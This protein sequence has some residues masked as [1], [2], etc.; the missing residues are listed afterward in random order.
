[1]P[2][3]RIAHMKSYLVNIEDR[4]IRMESGGVSTFVSFDDLELTAKNICRIQFPSKPIHS[5]LERVADL[6]V[7]NPH[8]VLRFYGNY[9]ED[10]I[11]WCLLRNIQ[12]LHIDL[13]NTKSLNQI[14][15]LKHLKVLGI[16]KNVHTS[17]SLN[18]LRDLEN[19]EELFTSI[20]KDIHVVGSL[21][22]LRLV[23]LSEIK[24]N[25]LDFLS[26]SDNLSELWLSLGSLRNFEGL[27]KID[28]LSRLSIHQVRGF[29]DPM[30]SFVLSSCRSLEY[31]ELTNLTGIRSLDFI[32][33]LSA[34]F[35]LN[36][37]G[38]KNLN[39]FDPI[40]KNSTLKRI[41]GYNCR[42][43]DKSLKG[44]E[45]IESIGLGDSYTRDEV[46]NFVDRFNGQNLWIR[47]RQ[48]KGLN[49]YIS[50][51]SMLYQ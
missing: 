28:K 8:I 21:K 16:S 29:E 6:I 23:S 39:S 18:I 48:L 34:L 35:S 4:K 30:A 15:D 22:K 49:D 13:W 27:S 36:I 43:L 25:N 32:A 26:G 10:Q 12:K 41:S 31:L 5:V 45:D 24:T 33:N 9:T 50:R 37:E 51:L 40:S 38:L 1:M 47:G 3:F 20:S 14:S 7:K 11:E 17:V 2:H 42:P 46:N 44:L 19:I